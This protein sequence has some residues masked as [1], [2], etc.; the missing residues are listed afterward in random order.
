MRQPVEN[1]HFVA[2]ILKKLLQLNI[3]TK[4]RPEEAQ[5]LPRLLVVNVS[6][7]PRPVWSPPPP[8]AA[9]LG[10]GGP[11]PALGVIGTGWAVEKRRV[12]EPPW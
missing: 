12:R 4:S 9:R 6:A 1:C 2:N 11:V 10:G 3:F 7:Q 8:V 5:R